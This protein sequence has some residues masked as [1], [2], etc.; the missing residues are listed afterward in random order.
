MLA[1]MRWCSD[2]R[3]DATVPTTIRDAIVE[4][5]SAVAA[6]KLEQQLWEEK[7]DVAIVGGESF[8]RVDFPLAPTVA[9]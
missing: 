3:V 1:E 8:M 4:H 2:H 5:A 6:V 7:P 9:T